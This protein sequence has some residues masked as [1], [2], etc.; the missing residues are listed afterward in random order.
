VLLHLMRRLYT[1]SGAYQVSC[2]SSSKTLPVGPPVGRLTSRL[3]TA[4]P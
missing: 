4:A 2:A 1:G 3:A